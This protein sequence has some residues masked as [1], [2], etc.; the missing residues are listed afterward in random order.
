MKAHF[1]MMAN[2]NEW[3][4]THLFRAAAASIRSSRWPA[5]GGSC[6][7]LVANPSTVPETRFEPATGRHFHSRAH[8]GS[9]MPPSA[10]ARL[11]RCQRCRL[12]C[13]SVPAA[14]AHMPN[15]PIRR[16]R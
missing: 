10:L 6:A 16:M 3:A 14:A 13:H 15:A 2:Y 12:T 1:V 11:G 4:N 5:G 9:M 7:L 8:A